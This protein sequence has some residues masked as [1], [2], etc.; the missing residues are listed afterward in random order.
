MKLKPPGCPGGLD[1]AKIWQNL[2]LDLLLLQENNK[3]SMLESDE[4]KFKTKKEKIIKFFR[5][6]F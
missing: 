5:K 4:K 2:P 6:I 3:Q 1:F